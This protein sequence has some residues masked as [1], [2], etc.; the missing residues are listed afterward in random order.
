MKERTIIVG[1]EITNEMANII[2]AELLHLDGASGDPITMY[3]N[4]AGGS[5][6]ATFAILDT[7]Q[8]LNCPIETICM[9]SASSL[10]AFLL[11]AG[12]KGHRKSFPNSRIMLQYPID[13]FEGEVSS[14]KGVQNAT[15][16]SLM[17]CM[18]CFL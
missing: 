11:A 3:I 14:L 10:G 13:E 4:C 18:F 6:P 15:K 8:F 9:G 1:Q 2:V 17:G 7:M 12:T 5:I 16:L